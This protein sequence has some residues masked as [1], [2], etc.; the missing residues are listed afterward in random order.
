MIEEKELQESLQDYYSKT[1]P[2]YIRY[3]KIILILFA[4]TENPILGITL[5]GYVIV[6]DGIIA[7]MWKQLRCAITEGETKRGGKKEG[8]REPETTPD[9]IFPY[10]DC[11]VEN[12]G[13]RFFITKPD[14]KRVQ[15][16]FDNF[17]DAKA[18]IDFLQPFI[19]V[20]KSKKRR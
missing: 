13:G 20:R 10:K 18:E 1:V 3:T 19:D 16:E 2:P 6:T 17:E 8:F 14:G 11:I 5:W 7:K 4:L 15:T 12:F 9:K